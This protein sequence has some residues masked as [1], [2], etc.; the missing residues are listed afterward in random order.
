MSAKLVRCYDSIMKVC[1]KC[2]S[3]K[4]ESN[5]F[6]R[7]KKTGRLHAQCKNCYKLYRK[8][9]QKEHYKK[10]KNEYLKRATMRRQR[11]RDEYR[12]NMIL[13][14]KD[15]SCQLCSEDDIRTFEF[16][17]ID[18][19][20]KLF[21]ISQGVKM[22]YNWTEILTEIKKCRIL[23]ANCHKKHTSNQLLWYKEANGGTER[24]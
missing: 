6:I 21:S 8:S 16:D 14:L 11:L 15:K 24:I 5:F 12:T 4:D 20:S 13:F 23:C 9:Y 7:N 10:Y 3:R 1:N 19:E 2:L 17:H 18:P 22:G